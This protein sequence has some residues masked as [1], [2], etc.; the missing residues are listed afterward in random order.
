[1]CLHMA[2]QGLTRGIECTQVYGRQPRWKKYAKR[3]MQR[4]PDA[5]FE[6]VVDKLAEL[7]QQAW[8]LQSSRDASTAS[9]R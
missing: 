1:M 6:E 7:T 9:S 5:R 2:G 8:A 3:M 4:S